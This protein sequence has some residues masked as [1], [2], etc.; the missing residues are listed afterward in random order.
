MSAQFDPEAWVSGPLHQLALRMRTAARRALLEA[1][2]HGTLDAIARPHSIGAGDVTYGIDV[3]TEIVLDRW[4]EEIAAKAPISLLTEDAGW[5]HRGPGKT[6]RVVELD[7][8]DHGGPRI[9]VDPIDGTRNLMTDLRSAWSVIAVCEPGESE[10]WMRDV[11]GGVLAEIPDSRGDHA[12]VFQATRGG[13]VV[14][15]HER[16]SDGAWLTRGA[17]RADADARADNGY[18]PFF[19]Y[20]ADMRP[21]IADIEARF[22]ARLAEHE[23]SDVRTCYDDQY[24]SN[25]GHLAL[26]TLGTYRMIADLRQ[27]LALR[28]GQPTMTTKPYDI[29][30]AVL[31]ARTAGCIVTAVGGGELDFPL[32]VKTPISF[33]GWANEATRARLEPHLNAVLGL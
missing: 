3:P 9:V 11:T 17:W 23:K 10:P 27:W 30:G 12:R 33:V 16:S 14:L 18:F 1:I 19:R 7:G 15:A 31:V 22:F 25:G 24:I 29:A 32:D 21:S 8:F 26:L 4:L 6:G 13:R 28:R 2:D 5:R 20:L